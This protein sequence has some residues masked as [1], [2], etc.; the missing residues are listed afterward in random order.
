[1][2]SVCG[3]SAFPGDIS[4]D[5]SDFQRHARTTSC[6]LSGSES[7]RFPI[8]DCARVPAAS[9]HRGSAGESS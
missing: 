6:V 4:A 5:I 8:H 3:K 2:V 1:M 7:R 9:M